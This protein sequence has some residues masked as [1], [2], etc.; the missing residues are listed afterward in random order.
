[1]KFK[2]PFLGVCLLL[3]LF[4]GGPLALAGNHPPEME[5]SRRLLDVLDEMSEQY[6]VFFSYETSLLR[7]IEVNF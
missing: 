4:G 5:R 2:Q 6:Q 3:C 7:E 1:M